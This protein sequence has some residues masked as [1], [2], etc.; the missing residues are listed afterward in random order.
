MMPA[1]AQAG[2]ARD[3]RATP[4]AESAAKC[5]GLRQAKE[6]EGPSHLHLDGRHA[7]S[8]IQEMKDGG[9]GSGA[10]KHLAARWRRLGQQGEE[11]CD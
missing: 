3:D 7:K 2:R 1:G 4:P 9:Q 10:L 11:P 8:P 6:Q 5:D